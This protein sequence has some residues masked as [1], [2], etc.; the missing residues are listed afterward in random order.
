MTELTLLTKTYNVH[1]L[2]QVDRLLRLQFEGLDV[3]A[4][5]AAAAAGRWVQVSLSGED[6]AVA[7]NYMRK[8]FGF[9]PV[10]LENVKKYSTLKGYIVNL[11]KSPDTLLVDVGVFQ[12]AIVYATVPLRHLQATL[13]DGRKLAL[14]KIAELFGFCEHMPISIK[15]TALDMEKNI[16]EAELA[17]EQL[18]R[19]VA[20][21]ESLLD[22]LIVLGSSLKE[23]KR[24]LN[25]TGL[26]RDIISIESL[27]IFEYALTCKLGTDAAGLISQVGRNLRNAR[28][29]VFNPRKIREILKP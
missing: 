1:Q 18:E 17:T 10:S 2:K 21:Q 13:A 27:G 26:D 7:T 25:Y 6:E 3:E 5:V 8:E 4:K 11:G 29:V 19:F 9:C 28:F 20:W 23:V 22:R 12:P 24:M 14:K 15:V 16:A